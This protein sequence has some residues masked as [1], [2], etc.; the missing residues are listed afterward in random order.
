[1]TTSRYRVNGINYTTEVFAS[2]PDQ[3]IIVRIF[4]DKTGVVNFSATMTR[5][6]KSNITT[7]GNDELVLSGITSDHETVKGAVQFATHIKILTHGGSTS[8]SES[9][10]H[11]FDAD[12]ATIYISIASNFV[13]YS[14]IS[15]NAFERASAYLQHALKKDYKQ[16]IDDHIKD[17]RQYFKRVNLNLGTTDAIKILLMCVSN[18]FLEVMIPKWLRCIFNLDVIC[19]FLHQGQVGSQP[20]CRG[21]GMMNYFH[22][23]IVNIQLI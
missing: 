3:V 23:G 9:S 15:G 21:F 8:T 16:I 5:P 6:S 22:H 14:D 13:N 7:K 11:V 10:L 19:S 18:S 1:M 2:Y 4:G 20:T 12:T 17:Y